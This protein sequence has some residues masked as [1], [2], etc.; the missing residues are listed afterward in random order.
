MNTAYKGRKVVYLDSG[1]TSQKPQVVIDAINQYYRL[2]NA[3]IHRGIYRLSETATR[4]WSEAHEVVARLIGA[5]AEEVIFTRNT[6]EALNL[7]SYTLLPLLQG[8]TEIVAGAMEHHANLVP[9]QQMAKRHGLTLKIIPML[10]DFTLDMTAAQQLIGSKTAIVAIGHVSNALGTIHDVHKL[11]AWAKALGALTVLDAAQS[12]PHLNL[13]VGKIGADF[14]ALSAHKMLGP[15]G[16]G[17]LYGRRDL[18]EQMQPW[19]FGGDMIAEVSYDDA[20]WNELPMKFEAGTP[21]IAGAAGIV[22]AI[23]Y[24]KSVGLEAIGAW[25]KELLKYAIAELGDVPGIKLYSAGE[26]RSAGILSF[27]LATVHPHD[28]ASLLSDDEICVRAGHHCAM[29]LM[30]RLGVSATARASFYLYNTFEDVDMLK[31]GLIKAV[32]LFG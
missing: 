29:P 3:N 24:L 12:A 13:D 23:G 11:F 22:A 19:Q 32:E 17:F 18:L 14:A 8:R 16:L 25:E 26:Q 20:K 21:H 31:V 10:A 1:A 30:G 27:T 9:W 15:T 4:I 28:L 5:K 7:L 2:E 6:T